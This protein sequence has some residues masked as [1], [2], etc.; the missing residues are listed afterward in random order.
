MADKLMQIVEELKVASQSIP[1]E[2]DGRQSILEM[3]NAGS[4]HWRQMEWMGWY[5]EFQCE[6]HFGSIL[7]IPGPNFGNVTFDAFGE[8][9]WDFKAH[10][11]NSTGGVVIANDTE[12]VAA[13]LDTYGHY[14]V[15]LAI[16]DV[17]YNDDKRTFKKWHDELKGGKSEYEINRIKR[18]AMSRQRKT[19]FSLAE[20]HF[21]SLKEEHLRVCGV[22]FQEGFRNS[23]GSA[24]RPKVSIRIGDIP[25]EALL[26]SYVFSSVE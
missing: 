22:S 12:A 9:P 21:I 10:A 14:G 25:D 1:R 16:G 18:G 5:F 15:I 24:R 19:A 3:K 7:Q 2:W 13:M 4:R 8:I 26:A 23:D 11:A 17:E 6:R 20:L